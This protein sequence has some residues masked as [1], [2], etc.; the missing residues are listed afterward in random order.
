MIRFVCLLLST[1]TFTA[2]ANELMKLYISEEDWEYNDLVVSV[3]GYKVPTRA[4]FRG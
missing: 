4:A 1:L 3:K 2:S